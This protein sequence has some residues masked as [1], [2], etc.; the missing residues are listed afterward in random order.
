MLSKV[1]RKRDCRLRVLSVFL[2]APLPLKVLV[3]ARLWTLEFITKFILVQRCDDA[4]SKGDDVGR[5]G[6]RK[7]L[8][9]KCF[10][11]P[12]VGLADSNSRGSPSL[13]LNASVRVGSASRETWA[14]PP[15]RAVRPTGRPPP[16][17][18]IF[19]GALATAGRS[20]IP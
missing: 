15:S 3:P 14:S 17:Y 12:R 11:Q 8:A 10:T 4:I 7:I 2:F 19:R 16:G 9:P 20:T 1:V 13:Q 5:Q 6:T 18:S